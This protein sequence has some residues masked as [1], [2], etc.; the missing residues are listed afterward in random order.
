MKTI[1]IYLLLTISAFFI[2]PVYAQKG[3]GRIDVSYSAAYPTGSFKDFVSDGSYRGVDIKILFG[4]SDNLSVGFGTGFQDFYQKYPRQVYKLADGSDV[5]AVV[6]NSLQ[7]VPLLAR[8]EYNFM[9]EG[10]VNPFVAAG[11]GGD[12]VLYRQYLGEF[13]DSKNKFAFQAQPEAGVF[14]PFRA[15]G[16]TGIKISGYYNVIPFKYNGM[17]NLNNF[18]FKIGISFPTRS[19]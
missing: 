17:D 9:P 7:T 13:G 15:G 4:I 10:R 19:Y 14:Y 18:G 8:A 2:L 5:S 16:Q 3:G 12:I 11:V 1:K 6:S